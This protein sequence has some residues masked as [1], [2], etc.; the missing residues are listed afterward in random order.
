MTAAGTAFQP[1]HGLYVVVIIVT[2]V[3]WALLELRQALHHRPGATR[4]DRGSQFVV[5]AGVGGGILVGL[6][7]A[8][9][10][11]AARIRPEA[12]A[13]WLGLVFV[14][15]GGGLRIWCFRTLGTY[16]TFTVQTSGDQ[17]VIDTG[18]YRWLRHPSYTG[19][20]FA[21]TG[22]GFFLDNWLAPLAILVGSSL[23]LAYRI[24]VEER[25]LVGEMGDR[26][27]DFAA[28]RKRLIPYVW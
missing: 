9:T 11:P 13:A 8:H 27:R 12:L 18:P 25:A 22:I 14:W 21:Y 7:L 10:V 23:G 6:L 2:V 1:V 15:C 17:P 5:R 3:P 16:F 20:L 26:Y 19:I 28:T 24:Q 4:S